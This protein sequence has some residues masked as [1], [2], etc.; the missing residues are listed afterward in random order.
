MRG[1]SG[2]VMRKPQLDI[3]EE[4]I[5]RLRKELEDISSGAGIKMEAEVRA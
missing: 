5:Q 2:G 3:D 1:I 4:E